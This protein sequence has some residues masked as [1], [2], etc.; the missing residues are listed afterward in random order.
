MFII[1]I[2]VRGQ[3]S[4]DWSD[5]MGGLQIAYPSSGIT[6]ISGVLPDQPALYAILSRL[7]A[8]NLTLIAVRCEPEGA[9]DA[10]DSFAMLKTGG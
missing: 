3:L 8:L 2:Q 7:A 6:A 5:W 4:T 10:R 1:E 9:D